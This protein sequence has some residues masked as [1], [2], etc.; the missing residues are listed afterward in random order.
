MPSREAMGCPVCGE[1]FDTEADCQGCGWGL[2]GQWRLG[3]TALDEGRLFDED[4]KRARRAF[5]AIAAARVD[6]EAGR[7]LPYIRGGRPDDAEWAAARLTARHETG[8]QGM[9][10]EVLTDAT[11]KVT[12]SGRLTVVE[13]GATG[14]AVFEVRADRLGTLECQAA[15]PSIGWTESAQMLSATADELRFQLAGGLADVDR[16]RLW[17]TLA[18]AVAATVRASSDPVVFVCTAPGWAVPERAAALLLGEHEAAQFVRSE[19]ALVPELLQELI[20]GSALRQPYELVMA[21]VH[22]QTRRVML[23]SRQLFPV[24]ARIGDRTTFT[25]RCAPSD[26]YG[27]VFA[28]T[29]WHDRVPHHLSVDSIRLRPGLHRVRA[30]LVGPGQVEFTEPRGVTADQRTWSELMDAIPAQLPAPIAAVDLICGIE[31]GGGDSAL[32]DER[33]KVI[34]RLLS[35]L[36]EECPEPDRVRVAVLGYGD[37]PFDARQDGNRIIFGA[38]LASL[39]EALDSVSKFRHLGQGYPAAAALEDMLS[40]VVGRLGPTASAPVP[41]RRTVLLTIGGRPPHPPSANVRSILPCPRGLN[42]DQLLRKLERYPDLSRIAVVDRLP[43]GNG[44]VWHRLGAHRM[45]EL[46]QADPR[47]LGTDIGVLVPDVHR[48]PFPLMK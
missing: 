35:D 13:I 3:G 17:A 14:I 20:S 11:D 19:G 4:L 25:V 12:G 2:Q 46:A 24:G 32:V 15:R 8:T 33:L 38:W 26:E 18:P 41:A 30:V 28:V 5:D 47:Q 10:R 29:T 36:S 40:Q 9:L 16:E 44:T 34:R 43:T 1:R 37:H 48:L 7:D 23:K 39:A 45:Y 31:L 6:P 21:V 27:T 22:P 42:W